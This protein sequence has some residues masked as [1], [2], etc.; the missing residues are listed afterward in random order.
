M[1]SNPS[2]L[3]E[4]RRLDG[5]SHGGLVDLMVRQTKRHIAF[6]RVVGQVNGLRDIS[7]LVLPTAHVLLDVLPIYHHAPGVRNEQSEDDVDQRALAAAARADKAHRFA[8]PD[9]E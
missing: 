2:E 8:L 6:Q 1:V 7:D 3:V 5:A 4:L 9:G